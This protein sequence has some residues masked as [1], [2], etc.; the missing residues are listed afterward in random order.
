MILAALLMSEW[1]RIATPRFDVISSAGERRTREMARDLETLAAAIG[2]GPPASKKTRVFIFL[3]R[4]EAQPYFDILLHREK[5]GVSGLFIAQGS[6]TA[7]LIDESHGPLRDRTPYHELVHYLLGTTTP[8]PP[9][10]LEEGLAEYYSSAEVHGGIIRVGNR[11]FEHMEMLQ[12]RTP[13]PLETLF[14]TDRESDISVTTLFYAEAW[15]VVDWMIVRDRAKFDAFMHDVTGGMTAEA[16]LQKHFRKSVPDLQRLITRDA[17]TSLPDLPTTLQ[18]RV[19][20]I[21]APAVHMRRADV[22]FEFARMLDAYEPA[23]AHAAEHYEAALAA[24]P[25]NGEIVLEYAEM[26]LRGDPNDAAAFRQAR[27]LAQRALDHGG[28]RA[29]ALGA[30]GTSYSVEADPTPGIAPLEQAVALAPNRSDLARL[31][32]NFHLHTDVPRVN[33]LLKEGKLDDAAALLRKMSASAPDA[34]ARRQMD[35]QARSIEADA[36]STRETLTYNLAV[37]LYNGRDLAGAKKVIDELV[38]SATDP[39]VIADAA[40]LQ[41]LIDERLKHRR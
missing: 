30:I 33:A 40:K 12:R 14:T 9:L 8:R 32:F 39:K 21:D 25:S 16:A 7:M 6:N 3:R 18:V 23:H 19:P 34:S 35:D 31:L 22:L 5:S 13:I 26:L 37:Q 36:A 10:W 1:V 41:T 15:A 28:D 29:R 27:E 24:D 2:S 11:I 20:E 38:K 4:P 17:V